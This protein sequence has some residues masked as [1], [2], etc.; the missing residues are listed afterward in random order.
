MDIVS[1]YIESVVTH[2][3]VIDLFSSWWDLQI[4]AGSDVAL[5]ITTHMSGASTSAAL[6]SGDTL[7]YVAQGSAWHTA[8][9][10]ALMEADDRIARIVDADAHNWYAVGMGA[11][12]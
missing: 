4:A 12:Q 10:R 1:D 3:E 11:T 9:M 5:N 2:E 8:L 6:V 7:A